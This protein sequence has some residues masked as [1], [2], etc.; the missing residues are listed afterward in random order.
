MH[1]SRLF[2]WELIFIL[3]LGGALWCITF[4]IP[5]HKE[6]TRSHAVEQVTAA[7]LSIEPVKVIPS[8]PVR[9]LIP[10]LSV[11]APVQSVGRATSSPEEMGVPTNFTDVA[12][13]NEGPT[14]GTLGSAVIDAH[15]NGKQLQKA[16]FYDLKT[17][18]LGDVGL[19]IVDE[20]GS[21]PVLLS[22]FV[23]VSLRYVV[24]QHIYICS[25]DASATLGF[26][27]A[28]TGPHLLDTNLVPR[29]VAR[30]G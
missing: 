7:G 17:L 5:S 15:F 29:I 13:Y 30:S 1:L 6:E 25:V 11:D 16:V 21:V 22:V 27:S 23:F 9:L 20:T 12:W 3:L 28:R 14:P 2:I 8:L 19:Y 26:T 24:T 10:A 4:I 18:E